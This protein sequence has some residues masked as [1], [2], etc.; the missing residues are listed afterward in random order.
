MLSKGQEI[1]EL[2]VAETAL[3]GIVI[4]HGWLPGC[5]YFFVF[6]FFGV[7][8]RVGGKVL[9]DEVVRVPPADVVIDHSPRGTRGAGSRFHVNHHR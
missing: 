6:F 4:P 3:V 8:I 2:P 9:C 5:G 7:D 1:A